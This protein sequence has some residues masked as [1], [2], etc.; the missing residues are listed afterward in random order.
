MPSPIIALAIVCSFCTLVFRVVIARPPFSI[1]NTWTQIFTSMTL[2]VVIWIIGVILLMSP[3]IIQ[4]A[5]WNDIFCGILI[6]LCAFWCQY[7]VGNFAGG[8]RVQM[9]INLAQQKEPIS[10]EEWMNTFGG[11]G[12]EMFLHDR[13]RSILIPSNTVELKDGELRLVTGWGTFFGRVMKF[14]KI[15]LLQ[16]RS[17]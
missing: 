13:I 11:L 1:K 12:M 8:F 10:I 14:L 15:I 16:V 9:Q 7:W 17:D 2:S 5:S 3:P 4:N 6:L